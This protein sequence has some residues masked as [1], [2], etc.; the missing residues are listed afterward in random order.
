MNIRIIIV[1]IKYNIPISE[2]QLISK[3]L[4]AERIMGTRSDYYLKK[5]GTKSINL[6]FFAFELGYHCPICGTHPEEVDGDNEIEL[7]HIGF[8]EY[9]DF[10]FCK[11]CNIDI[12]SFLCLKP[13]N[14]EELEIY[15]NRYLDAIELFKNGEY[16]NIKEKRSKEQFVCPDCGSPHKLN[17]QVPDIKCDRCSQ[18]FPET[19]SKGE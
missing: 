9:I 18:I 5:H 15:I 3:N 11:R 17:I 19:E 1:Y 7:M 6:I 2:I 14:K 8:S 16:D 13:R 10:M 4:K 12:P